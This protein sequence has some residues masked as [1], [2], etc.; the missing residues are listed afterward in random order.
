MNLR[1]WIQIECSKWEVNFSEWLIFQVINFS[2]WLR[3]Q[4][5]NFSEWLIS[6]FQ[7][8][9]MI[10]FSISISLSDWS[11]SISIFL[12]WLRFQFQF[13]WA[14]DLFQ[15]QFSLS[16]WDF[17]FNFPWVIDFSI[18]ISLSDWSLSISIFLEWL[19]F[20][21]INFSEWLNSFNFFERSTPVERLKF[22]VVNFYFFKRST[23]EWLRILIINLG[24]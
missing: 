18:S 14:I 13:L 8:L 10:D 9:W 6:Q 22:V 3:F 5:I 12:E 11:L 19:R 16:D 2:D 23:H 7:F 24:D 15:F 4:F 17:N 1:S 21:F 20:Q